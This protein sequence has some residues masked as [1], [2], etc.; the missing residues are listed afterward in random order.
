[1]AFQAITATEIEVG[2]P[3]TTGLWGKVKDSLDYLY[4]LAGPQAG[5]SGVGNG[6]FEVDADSDGEP[7]TWSVGIHPGGTVT[8][9]TTGALHGVNCMKFVHPGGAGN[10]GGY[11]Q[12]DYMEVGPAIGGVLCLAYYSTAAGLKVRIDA[13]WYDATKTSIATQTLYS[14]TANPTSWMSLAIPNLILATAAARYV[15]FTF[16]GGYTDTDVAGSV[17]LDDV[18]LMEAVPPKGLIAVAETIDIAI[19]GTTNYLAWGDVGSTAAINVPSGMKTMRVGGAIRGSG[20]SCGLRFRLGAN[21]STELTWVD[22][23]LDGEMTL[24][25]SALAGAQTFA[26]QDNRSVDGTFT[27]GSP[28]ATH[29]KAYNYLRRVSDYLTGA[30]TDS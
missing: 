18:R 9:E 6:S 2:K 10:G 22:T 15:R 28:A 26:L 1:M 29:R 30:V 21:Y 14:S 19:Q 20:D 11:V 3:I 25:V 23:D 13:T 24:D 5:A 12:S 8:L 17:Y 7:D 27:V 4:G 16:H